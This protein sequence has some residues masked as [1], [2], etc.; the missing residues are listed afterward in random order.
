MGKCI[1]TSFY[2]CFIWVL[3]ILSSV[4]YK[5]LEIIPESLLSAQL[6]L[7]CFSNLLLASDQFR[8]LWSLCDWF[9]VM[10]AR[11]LKNGE[12]EREERMGMAE[13]NYYNY[14]VCMKTSFTCAILKV[15][16]VFQK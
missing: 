4:T 12:R 15:Q 6:Q 2:L 1:E 3:C 13:D 10:Q 16:C 14:H 7:C 11:G 5:H 8:S 9:G